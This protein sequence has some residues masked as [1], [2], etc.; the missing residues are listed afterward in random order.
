MNKS[1]P[2]SSDKLLVRWLQESG[3]RRVD[4]RVAELHRT[5]TARAWAA[6]AAT[7]KPNGVTHSRVL[8]L[9]GLLV[10]VYLNYLYADVRAQITD[11]P[12][13]TVFVFAQS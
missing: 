12:V 8:L 5:E 1:N 6:P 10:V 3:R 7:T 13:V 11:M 9:F 4:P 2:D